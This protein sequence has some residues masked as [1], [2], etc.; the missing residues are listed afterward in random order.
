MN[1]KSI[2]SFI[3]VIVC[4]RSFNCEEEKQEMSIDGSSIMTPSKFK[5][6]FEFSKLI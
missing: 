4:L 5:A 6:K 3:F 1:L 2:S